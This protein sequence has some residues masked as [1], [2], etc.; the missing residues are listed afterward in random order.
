MS[1]VLSWCEIPTES[2][3]NRPRL[4]EGK[5]SP[6][7]CEFVDG[8]LE[9]DIER[10]KLPAQLLVSPNLARVNIALMLSARHIRGWSSEEQRRWI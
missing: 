8:C 7:V 2:H 9:K 4:P 1:T 3:R 6:D 5:F 10:R